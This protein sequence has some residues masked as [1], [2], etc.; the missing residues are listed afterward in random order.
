MFALQV[1][2]TNPVMLQNPTLSGGQNGPQK[3]QQY[4][5]LL[6]AHQGQKMS[7]L[8]K[9]T[10]KALP[11]ILLET[12]DVETD[13]ATINAS[14]GLQMS[15]SITAFSGGLGMTPQ[16][17]ANLQ[18]H[19]HMLSMGMPSM[20]LSGTIPGASDCSFQ[21]PYQFPASSFSMQRSV[22]PTSDFQMGGSKAQKM[23]GAGH[24]KAKDEEDVQ[25]AM[26]RPRLIWTSQLHERFVE[27]VNKMG[28]DQAVPKAIMQSMN[29]KG[30]TRE[31]VASHLQKYRAQLKKNKA[32]LANEQKEAEQKEAVK[33]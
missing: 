16:H 10:H 23:Q 32:L 25:M 30:I 2:T 15:D 5:K 11:D 6:A 21:L 14:S 7:E 27:A 22:L 18:A 29:V 13:T 19:T 9:D 3:Q 26:K 31:N 20:G 4:Q 33:S 8:I 28:V 12:F 1:P 17:F 24:Q